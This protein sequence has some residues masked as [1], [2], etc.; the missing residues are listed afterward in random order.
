MTADAYI[1]GKS[2]KDYFFQS[3]TIDDES[4]CFPVNIFLFAKLFKHSNSG[5]HEWVHTSKDKATYK[6]CL[7]SDPNV[8]K[9]FINNDLIEDENYKIKILYIKN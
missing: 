1:T 7:Q 2:G 4:D 9:D 8:D 5:V 3:F 6:L